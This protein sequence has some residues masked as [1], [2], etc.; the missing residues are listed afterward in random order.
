MRFPR[1]GLRPEGL[2]LNRAM[3]GS[4]PP[5][6]LRVLPAQPDDPGSVPILP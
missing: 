3:A 1:G 4:W 5:L 6:R 2:Y